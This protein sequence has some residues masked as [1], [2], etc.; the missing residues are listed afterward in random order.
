MRRPV[1]VLVV[2]F[3]MLWQSITLARPGSTVRLLED[4]E[5]AALHWQAAG[6]HHHDDGTYH[7]DDSSESVQHVVTDHASASAAALIASIDHDF[8]IAPSEKPSALR[9]ALVTHPFLDGLLRP[10]RLR[11]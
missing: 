7:V 6:H 10:P 3:A 5:H 8:A 11:S 2:L 1:I 4:F 9:Q